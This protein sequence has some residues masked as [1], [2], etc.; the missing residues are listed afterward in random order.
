LD[1]SEP[2]K[3]V[4]WDMTVEDR[5][6]SGRSLDLYQREM[7]HKCQTS[8]LILNIQCDIYQQ[9]NKIKWTNAV[10]YF[11]MENSLS[12][13]FVSKKFGV[14]VLINLNIIIFMNLKN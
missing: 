10:I 4:I 11:S 9:N 14:S 5:V 13:N 3:E 6:G 1:Y 12:S 7:S 2:T 8:R